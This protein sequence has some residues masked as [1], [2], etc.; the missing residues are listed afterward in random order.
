MHRVAILALAMA[1]THQAAPAEGRDWA[2]SPPGRFQLVPVADHGGTLLL[3]DTREGQ[4]F[5][6]KVP[7]DNAT[8][9][10]ALGA[11]QWLGGPEE[12][13]RYRQAAE[14]TSMQ[15]LGAKPEVIEKAEKKLESRWRAI[16]P[17]R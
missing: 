4:V 14:V 8:L 17:A 12:G 15:R 16:Y 3:V 13:Y 6:V 10:D 5:L 1:G 2:G 9:E 11:V 7:K